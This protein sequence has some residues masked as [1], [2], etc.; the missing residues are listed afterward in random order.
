MLF[1]VPSSRASVRPRRSS[2]TNVALATLFLACAGSSGAAFAQKF[3]TN[4]SLTPQKR[5][6]ATAPAPAPVTLLL[7]LPSASTPPTATGDAIQDAFNWSNY[8]RAQSGLGPLQRVSKL[9][10]SAQAHADYTALNET[11]N[12]GHDETKGRPGFAGASIEDRMAAQGY[13]SIEAGENMAFGDIGGAGRMFTDQL[14]D[15]PYHRTGQMGNFA[16]AGA[17]TKDSFTGDDPLSP[18]TR[19]VIDFGSLENSAQLKNRLWAYPGPGQKEILPDWTV[20][21]A[22][23]PW[24]SR[25]DERVGYPITLQAMNSG[26]LLPD[27]FTLTDERGQEIPVLA[28]TDYAENEFHELPSTNKMGNFA[29]WIPEDPLKPATTYTTKVT[30]TL[31]GKRFD[32]KWNFTTIAYTPLK[33]SASAPSFKGPSSAVTLTFSGGSGRYQIKDWSIRYEDSF[34][35]YPD[36]EFPRA[37]T[38][39]QFTINRN[40]VSCPADVQPCARVKLKLEDSA[41]NTKSLTF[42]IY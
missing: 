1:S 17:A 13:A 11:R 14:I 5:A 24:P 31:N 40:N 19:Y 41:G 28:V 10:R 32:V 38:S 6:A 9:D 22:P 15:A 33:V 26:E 29:L 2:C 37:L 34:E 16:H 4:E 3:Y 27:S 35:Q 20:S 42:P 18:F 30:G 25:D 12:E 39:N 7:P 36:I 8:R 21:E 23:S